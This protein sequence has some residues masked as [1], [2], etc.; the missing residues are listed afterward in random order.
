[1]FRY[2]K[3]VPRYLP[4]YGKRHQFLHQNKY[5]SFIACTQFRVII[6]SKHDGRHIFIF[7]ELDTNHIAQESHIIHHVDH[8]RISVAV[9]I[10]HFRW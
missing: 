1:M 6:I 9:N 7:S 10:I 8:V 3:L 2:R 4:I 5:H